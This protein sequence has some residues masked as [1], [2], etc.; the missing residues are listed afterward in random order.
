M[1]KIGGIVESTGIQPSSRRMIAALD[2]HA[3][4]VIYGEC[5]ITPYEA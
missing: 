2:G 1:F 3:I 4:S 5:R